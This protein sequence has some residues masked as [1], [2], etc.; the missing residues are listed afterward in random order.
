[1]SKSQWL[2]SS[3]LALAMGLTAASASAETLRVYFNAGHAYETYL[4]A[5]EKFEADNPGWDVQFEKFQWPDL[6]TKL[7]ADFAADNAPDLVATAGGWVPE[8]AFQDLLMPLD[9]FAARDA[10]EFDFPGDWFDPAIAKNTVNGKIYGL[11]IHLTCATLVYNK[12]MLAEAGY[13]SPP[14]TWDEFREVANATTKPGVFGFAPNSSFFY[15]W[16]WVFQN[17]GEY[18]DTETGEVGFGSE[19]TIGAMQF[20]ADLI[21]KDRAAPVPVAGA[22]YEGP[23]KLFTSERAAMILTGPWDINPIRTGNPDLNWAV[24]PSLSNAK[25]AT[26]QG[27]VALAIPKGAQHADMAWELAKR[28]TDVEVEVATSLQYSM[29]MPRKSWLADERVQADPLLGQFGSCLPYSMDVQLPLTLTGKYDPAVDAVMR[30]AVE[31]VLYSNEPA[32]EVLPV[33]AEE[34]NKIIAA[35]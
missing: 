24:A 17:G 28:L 4:E 18:F 33:A 20:L 14:T 26:V 12:D 3:A 9:D 31:E 19:E 16:P 27:G 8:F 13:D 2:K 32:A 29:T 30:Q 34:A 1:M 25:Q 22:D 11:Q 15:Y 6:R 21:H 7:V 5:I 35:K 10:A 23:Q